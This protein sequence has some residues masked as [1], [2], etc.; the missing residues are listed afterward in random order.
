[1]K[2][3]P[4]FILYFCA[5]QCPGFKSIELWDL[6][7]TARREMNFE[8]AVVHPQLCT[9]AGKKFLKDC[10]KKDGPYIIG[11]CDPVTQ[12]KLMKGVF[13]EIGLD[14]GKQVIA[15][16]LKKMTTEQAVDKVRATVQQIP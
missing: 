3:K 9:D 7:N 1:M 10:I 14:F 4:R 13:K 11:G 6:I 12:K 8:S 5:G 2:K 15:L 16:E